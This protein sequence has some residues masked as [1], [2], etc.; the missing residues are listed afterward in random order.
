MFHS[1]TTFPAK[2]I[3]KSLKSKK[4]YFLSKYRNCPSDFHD[5]L[6]VKYYI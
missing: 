2:S 3:F 5:L 1:F 4:G 6:L